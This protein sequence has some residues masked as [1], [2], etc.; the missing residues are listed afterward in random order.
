MTIW[1]TI[2][3]VGLLTYGTRLSSIVLLGHKKIPASLSRTLRFVPPAVLSALI[4]PALL[5]S[6]DNQTISL[7]NERLIAGLI[8]AIIAWRTKNVMLTII[9]GMVVLL[10]LREYL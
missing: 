1:V 10:L 4:F 8:A 7:L 5:L 9:V 2:I 3:I 6:S